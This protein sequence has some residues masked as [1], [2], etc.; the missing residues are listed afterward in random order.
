LLIGTDCPAL[1]GAAINHAAAQ[2]Q[3]HDAVF[4]PTED[5]GYALVGIH[6]RVAN[7]KSVFAAI[8]HGM[9]WSTPL[10]M[11][12]TLARL[13]AL[14][15]RYALSP[16]LWDVDEPADL[17]RLRALLPGALDTTHKA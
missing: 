14:A 11:A 7:R 17:P 12:T 9:P 2:L 4:V 10:V 8:F 16:T 1:D 3:A 15:A 6:A 5:G 13:D